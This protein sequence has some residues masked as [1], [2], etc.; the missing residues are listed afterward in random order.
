VL[1]GASKNEKQL[2]EFILYSNDVNLINA[3]NFQCRILGAKSNIVPIK[4]SIPK[5][6]TTSI[7][8]LPSL[9]KVEQQIFNMLKKPQGLFAIQETLNLSKPDF[10][11]AVNKLRDA[12]KIK[13]CSKN[14]KNWLQV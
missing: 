6:V 10:T 2:A 14:G 13:R 5:R 7:S 3:F 12:N 9:D 8:K 1:A 11:K 4:P